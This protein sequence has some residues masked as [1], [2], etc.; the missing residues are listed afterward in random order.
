M[1][2]KTGKRFLRKKSD[3][4]HDYFLSATATGIFMYVLYKYNLYV[5]PAD[6]SEEI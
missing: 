5:N 3:L 1:F 2:S 6:A 4:I